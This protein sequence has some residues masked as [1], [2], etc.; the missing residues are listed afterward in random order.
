MICGISRVFIKLKQ[1]FLLLNLQNW[2]YIFSNANRVIF[3]FFNSQ[4]TVGAPPTSKDGPAP[5]GAFTCA[6]KVIGGYYA[7]IYE[8][9]QMFHVCTIG[10]NGML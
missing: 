10:E 1:D 4:I 2:N 3:F 8:N 6:G 7:D 9:C 5:A